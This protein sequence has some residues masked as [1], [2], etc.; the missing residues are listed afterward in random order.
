MINSAYLSRLLAS[1][2]LAAALALPAGSAFAAASTGDYVG[3]TAAEITESLVQQGYEVS[4]IIFE[5][6]VVLDGKPYEITLDPRT[7]EIV[8]IE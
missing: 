8:E 2:A 5:I 4:E 7:G 6:K 1:A 3:T